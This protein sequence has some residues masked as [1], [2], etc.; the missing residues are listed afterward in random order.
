[1]TKESQ[2]KLNAPAPKHRDFNLDL[3]RILALVF[4]V[5]VH[6]FLHNGFY[7]NTLSTLNMYIMGLMRTLFLCCV[8]LFMLL[9]GYLQ[10]SKEINPN[11][12]YYIKLLKTLIPYLVIMFIDMLYYIIRENK[13]YTLREAV[14]NFTSFT[15][16]SWYVEMY[17]GLF[18]IAPFLN[19]L[20]FN[21]KTRKN[22]HILIITLLILTVVPY[23]FN[24]Y[25][26]DGTENGSFWSAS[27]ND[28]W[29]L[30]PSWWTGIYPLT[31][32]FVGAYLRK[33]KEALKMK[34][35]Y[36]FLIFLGVFALFGTY[37][38]S[39]SRGV[40]LS[41]FS[42]TDYKSPGIF[43]MSTSLFYFINNINFKKVPN[44]VRK[45]AGKLSDL[46]FGA[47]LGSWVMDYL[48]YNHYKA[49]IPDMDDRLYYYVPI[50]LFHLCG[51]FVISFFANAVYEIP[52][53][54]LALHRKN[55]AKKSKT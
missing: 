42:W 27:N 10:S 44:L 20:W 41:V 21:L 36:A 33:Y 16:Y 39:R 14:E 29:K 23:L 38:L 55:K 34:A 52:S 32:Y 9:T 54:L 48:M 19:I 2:V 37:T 46:T 24:V 6:F 43:L 11:K 28:Y 8:P 49:Q 4:V 17:I 3:I 15:H 45:C 25:E 12:H 53:L 51:A 40:A 31:Y 5:S 7:S 47:Y 22:E 18:L 1:M 13:E 50:V 35:I 30:F 26:F